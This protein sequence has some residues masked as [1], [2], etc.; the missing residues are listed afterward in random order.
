MK[1]INYVKLSLDLLMA[2]TFVLLFNTRILGGLAFHEI[3]GLAI[4]VACLTHMA[5]N[6]RWIKGV[7]LKILDRKLPVKTRFEY[8]LNLVLLFSM[9]FIIVSGILISRVVF[10]NLHVGDEQWFKTTHISVSF[11]TLAIVGVHVGLHWQWVMNVTR[12][13]LG[14]SSKASRPA[15]IV[16]KLAMAA[17]L[18]I[19]V[20]EMVQTNF[21]EH[22]SSVASVFGG[23]SSAGFEDHGRMEKGMG[24]GDWQA[25]D[26]AGT[27]GGNAANEGESGQLGSANPGFGDRMDGGFAEH[28]GG[29][30]G[31]GG[32]SAWDVLLTYLGIMG[33]FVI[34]VYYLSRLMS[35]RKAAKS[36]RPAASKE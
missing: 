24:R 30:R 2:V 27:T 16:L 22:L 5:L 23:S 6:I 18:A 33:V 36:L 9:A 11:L 17:V 7:T 12:R 32:G 25:G 13:L 35:R 29:D 10:P 21:A 28:G 19:G 8:L 1:K 15:G 4:G 14:R 3:A 31:F 26:G 34:A 20:Y